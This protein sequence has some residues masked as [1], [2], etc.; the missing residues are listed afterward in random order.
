MKNI[1]RIEYQGEKQIKAFEVHKEQLV[2]YNNE[3]VSSMHSKQKEIFEELANNRMEEIQDLRKQIDS[4][5]LPYHYKGN[6]APKT[7]IGYKGPLRFYRSIKEGYIT[8]QKADEDQ[9]EFKS[10]INKIVIGSNKSEDQKSVIIYIKTPYESREKVIK[11]FDNY[12]GIVS[13]AK[14]KAKQGKG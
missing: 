11:L 5:N 2:Q 3:K 6:T 7:L 4:N 12:F 9:K 10:K 8:L 14:C 13:E 1:K